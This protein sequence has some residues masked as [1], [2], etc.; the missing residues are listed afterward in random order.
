MT[1]MWHNLFNQSPNDVLHFHFFVSPGNNDAINMLVHASL[2]SGLLISMEQV[3]KHKTAGSKSICI[4]VKRPCQIPSPQILTT[5]IY[6]RNGWKL[7]PPLTPIS[8]QELDL[9]MYLF[10]CQ[11]SRCEEKVHCSSQ[12]F[13]LY[14]IAPSFESGLDDFTHTPPIPC[15]SVFQTMGHEVNAIDNT[16]QLYEIGYTIKVPYIIK[17]NNVLWSLFHFLHIHIYILSQ[18]V[19]YTK[20]LSQV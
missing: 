19:K 4:F 6:I 17:L 1:W 15:I 7:F 2:S 11:F 12:I 16:F 13:N 10:M 8:C 20:Y 18:N 14:F 9:F 5:P 3:P